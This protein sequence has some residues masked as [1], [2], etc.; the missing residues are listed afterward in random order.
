MTFGFVLGFSLVVIFLTN[1]KVPTL[2]WPSK[3]IKRENFTETLRFSFGRLN[4]LKE[5]RN[6]YWRQRAISLDSTVVMKTE[7]ITRVGGVSTARTKPN[8][9][10]LTGNKSTT[11]Q[12]K[13]L[14]PTCHS[15]WIFSSHCRAATGS[16]S[17][18]WY[19]AVTMSFSFCLRTF[20]YNRCHSLTAR[21]CL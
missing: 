9:M 16:R 17:S 2:T 6:R 4:F 8:N 3:H 11:K 20:H 5:N 14:A 10:Q 12:I 19:F 21:N 1:Q 7:S 13:A 15:I 18:W